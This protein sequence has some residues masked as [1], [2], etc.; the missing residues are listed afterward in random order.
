MTPSTGLKNVFP[1]DFG[2]KYQRK[3]AGFIAAQMLGLPQVKDE[4]GW[5][6]NDD[7]ETVF[8][9]IGCSVGQ[10]LWNRCHVQWCECHWLSVCSG[11]HD[12]FANTRGCSGAR[13]LGSGLLGAASSCHGA[14]RRRLAVP[15]SFARLRDGI[16]EK[17]EALVADSEHVRQ[18]L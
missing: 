12:V 5:K 18:H 10:G 9:G 3:K 6:D 15:S 1:L 4:I 16:P 2:D 7:V 13:Q 17:Y 14:H 8:Q 11:L